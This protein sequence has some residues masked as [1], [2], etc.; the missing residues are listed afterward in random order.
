MA[1]KNLDARQIDGMCTIGTLGSRFNA[2]LEIYEDKK[3]SRKDKKAA[4]SRMCSYY[5]LI[6]DAIKS[7]GLFGANIETITMIELFTSLDVRGRAKVITLADKLSR[8]EN[9]GKS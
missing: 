8:G 3:A 1:D 4:Y 2:A 9:N 6:Q 7:Y 5:N